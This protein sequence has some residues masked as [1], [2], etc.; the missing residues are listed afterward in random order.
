MP[1]LLF[2]IFFLIYYIPAKSQSRKFYTIK[3]DNS[4][5][6]IIFKVKAET[7]NYK[8]RPSNRSNVIDIFGSPNHENLNPSFTS[9]KIDHRIRSVNF[10]VENLYD[11][12]L[13]NL[14]VNESNLWEFFINEKKI[15]DFSFNSKIADANI[16]LSN[17]PIENIDLVS[18]NAN[19][20]IIYDKNGE[21]PLLMDSLKIKIEIGS[22]DTKNINLSNAKN[23]FTEIGFGNVILDIAQ[24]KKK[25]FVSKTNLSAGQLIINLPLDDIGTKIIINNSPLSSVKLPKN[26]QEIDQNIFVNNLSKNNSTYIRSFIVDVGLGNIT[27]NYKK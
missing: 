5:E 11:P 27:V 24:N 22:L 4:Y 13:S 12:I 25:P 17:I 18:G 16:N 2:I 7:G 15:Y 3:D 19:L 23:I 21:N 14:V 1:K 6:K 10:T 8:I 26:F 9:K 20:F